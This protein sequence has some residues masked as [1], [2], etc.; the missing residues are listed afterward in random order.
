MNL[1]QRALRKLGRVLR[2][3]KPAVVEQASAERIQSIEELAALPLKSDRDI[4]RVEIFMLKFRE[5]P[6]VIQNAVMSIITRTEHP[7]TLSVFDNRPNTA[8]MAK[9]W[10]KLIS[11]SSCD[12]VCI[13]D[14]D[15]EVPQLSPCWLTRLMESVDETGVVVPVGDNIGGANQAD[16]ALPYPSSRRERGIWT[17]FCMLFKK[18]VWE[19][20]HFDERFYLYGQESAWAFKLGKNGAGAV[21]RTDT[22]VHHE[23]GHSAKK[24]ETA[25][26]LD[27]TADKRYASALL[28]RIKKG[29][30]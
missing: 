2:G 10:N 16:A 9:V 18:S 17:G 29:E 21:V 11:Q 28:E 30:D 23:R 15:T 13:I 24:E 5:E 26:S 1:A 19:Q 20:M 8:N 3:E 4:R 22:L 25:G 27:R 14:S 12:Y 6:E 7:F